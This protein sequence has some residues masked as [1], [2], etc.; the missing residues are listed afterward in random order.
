MGGA[1][2]VTRDPGPGLGAQA[3]L[4]RGHH[5]SVIAGP[6]RCHPPGRI[7]HPPC[8]GPRDFLAAG[9][10]PG[11]GRRSRAPPHRADKDA[12]GGRQPAPDVDHNVAGP[13]P[14]L[15]W[16]GGVPR[17]GTS[18]AAAPAGPVTLLHPTR[19]GLCLA[20][21]T[22]KGEKIPGGAPTC[23]RT[24]LGRGR[25]GS[26]SQGVRARAPALVATG[27][28]QGQCLR[29]SSPTA[30]APRPSRVQARQVSPPGV[31][32]RPCFPRQPP[33]QERGSGGGV[34]NE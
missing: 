16:L 9:R 20:G 29:T 21:T 33:M 6:S 3:L 28:L 19:R 4:R 2:G 11:P 1:D 8:R 15:G 25:K 34:K 17:R 32:A 12:W 27:E 31:S 30:P 23:S 7:S 10:P 14:L 26:S 18:V 13:N 5:P 22:G 24:L